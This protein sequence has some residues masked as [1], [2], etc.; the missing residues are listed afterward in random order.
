[1]TAADVRLMP[2]SARAIITARQATAPAQLAPHAPAAR[3]EDCGYM[4]G[5][6]GHEATCGGT[7]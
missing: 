6:P 1:M 2:G 4:P 5:T 3:C 7:A